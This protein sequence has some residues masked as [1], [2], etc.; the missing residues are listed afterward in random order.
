MEV[1]YLF[2][3]FFLIGKGSWEKFGNFISFFFWF[4]IV[5][6]KCKGLGFFLIRWLV[7]GNV[8]FKLFNVLG[9]IIIVFNFLIFFVLYILVFIV[10]VILEIELWIIVVYKFVFV[11]W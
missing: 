1:Y 4:L 3:S 7:I 8:F 9:I 11:V 6:G 10:I 2:L 5:I